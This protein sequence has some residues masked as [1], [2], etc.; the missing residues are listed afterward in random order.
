M[1]RNQSEKVAEPSSVTC[2]SRCRSAE[3]ASSLTSALW[4]Q[5]ARA[6]IIC[7]SRAWTLSARRTTS[8]AARS[9]ASGAARFWSAVACGARPAVS[10]VAATSLR[11]VARLLRCRLRSR[12][13]LAQPA[14]GASQRRRNLSLARVH[15]GTLAKRV[16]P[17]SGL[18]PF[19][20][21]K[22][23]SSRKR[24]PL[25]WSM[26]CAMPLTVSARQ[27]ARPRN[28]FRRSNRRKLSTTATMA[29]TAVM[30][31]R[32]VA[33]DFISTSF[34]FG[35]FMGLVPGLPHLLRRRPERVFQK[36]SKA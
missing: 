2:C 12:Q 20:R 5:D 22:L 1:A 33:S 4:A 23:S 3:F 36:L 11:H 21:T 9:A 34:A 15:R 26:L 13:R 10:R 28:S 24:V 16:C 6:R 8:A 32:D 29:N 30:T 19:S 27:S 18:D 14:Q 31:P 25:P 17:R 35:C 7:S